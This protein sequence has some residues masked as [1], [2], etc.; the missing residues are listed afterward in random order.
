MKLL[1][2]FC[3]VLF[4]ILLILAGSYL[5]FAQE[6]T[7]KSSVLPKTEEYTLAYPGLLPDNPLYPL[8]VFRDRLVYFFI[9]DS[10]KKA[11][12]DILLA[13]KGLNGG[14]YLMQRKNKDEALAYATIAKG[15]KY[16]PNAIK[17]I[18][19]AKKQGIDISLVSKKLVNSIGEHQI[20]LMEIEKKTTSQFKEKIA[21]LSKETSS[22]LKEAIKLA[23]REDLSNSN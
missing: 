13:D 14:L 21:T 20:K 22:Y 5:S 12:F 15:E 10:L 1:R 17:S 16:F 18:T 2:F 8:K 3:I 9:S 7:S 11:E 6:L 23:P 4:F 19:E